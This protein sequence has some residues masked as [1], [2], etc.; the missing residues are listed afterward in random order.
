[1]YWTLSI[2]EQKANLRQISKHDRMSLTAFERETAE[3]EI[4]QSILRF[5]QSWAHE[6]TNDSTAFRNRAFAGSD[7]IVPTIALY[8]ATQ[9]E[10]NLDRCFQP[11]VQAGWRVVFPK[12][13]S[14]S[15]M[16][17]VQVNDMSDLVR[18][19]YGIREP[20]EGGQYAAATEIDCV[21]VP[22]LMFTNEGLRLGYGGGYYDRFLLGCRSDVR[23]IGI[24]FHCQI[25]DALPTHSHDIRMRAL[26]TERG[27]RNCETGQ[28]RLS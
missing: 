20:R 21:L 1:M 4:S 5:C 12:M 15:R 9:G 8:A 26:I 27:V 18:G 3:R 23:T 24:A 25:C 17:M 7:A 10:V 22:G 14:S 19:R 13:Q 28:L 11:L 6:V 2:D 16:N